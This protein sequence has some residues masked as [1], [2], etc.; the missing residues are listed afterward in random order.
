MRAKKL[1]TEDIADIVA[2]SNAGDTHSALAR[3]FG[4]APQT[5]DYHVRLS[6]QQPDPY[7]TQ[8]VAASQAR[9]AGN[10]AEAAQCFRNLAALVEGAA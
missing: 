2:R 10:A 7:H 3:E 1:T 9:R 5:I 6:K 4:V 8:L